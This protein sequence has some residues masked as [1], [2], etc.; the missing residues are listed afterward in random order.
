MKGKSRLKLRS[1]LKCQQPRLNDISSKDVKKVMYDPS[2][3][4][5]ILQENEHPSKR[6]CKLNWRSSQ[7]RPCKSI[8]TRGKRHRGPKL[9]FLR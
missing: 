1:F 2:L 4:Q 8:V 5:G 7:M 6:S 3:F 9:A